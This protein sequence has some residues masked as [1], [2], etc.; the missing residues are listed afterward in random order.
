MQSDERELG[1]SEAVSVI[2]LAANLGEGSLEVAL[3]E[4]VHPTNGGR[5][6]RQVG[7]VKVDLRRSRESAGSQRTTHSCK[8]TSWLVPPGQQT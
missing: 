3:V 1:W 7:G 6:L 4:V 8:L 5:K 2:E